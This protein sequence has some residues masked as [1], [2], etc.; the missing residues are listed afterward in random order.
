MIAS[1]LTA[2]TLVACT[3]AS[4]SVDLSWLSGTWR[5][6]SADGNGYGEVTF[7]PQYERRMAGVLRVV[8]K[9]Q[10][11]LME[12]IS[13]DATSGRVMLL[14]RHHLANLQPRDPEPLK[15][16]LVETCTRGAVFTN[17]LGKDA[18]PQRAS[19]WI[20]AEG[21]LH[22]RIDGIKAEGGQLREYEST[23]TRAQ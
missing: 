2:A 17:T 10:T 1:I 14:V 21:R 12:L 22:V 16:E 13:I 5:G 6:A 18:S 4:N 11:L 3:P 9:N 8:N 15:F 7:G 19:Y 23:L 20:D